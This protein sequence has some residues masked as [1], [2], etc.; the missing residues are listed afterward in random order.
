MTL[1][2]FTFEHHDG[3]RGLGVT[4]GRDEGPG[5]KAPEEET[6]SG[7]GVMR[8]GS[9]FDPGVWTWFPK[10]RVGQA[11]EGK[12]RDTLNEEFVSDNPRKYR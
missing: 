11:D 6:G 3:F 5:G 1:D 12:H 9:K 4:V 10:C 8:K 7:D 2:P